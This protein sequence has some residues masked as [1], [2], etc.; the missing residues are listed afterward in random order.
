VA[1]SSA[2]N[3]IKSTIVNSFDIEGNGE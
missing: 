1:Y 2:D 3:K